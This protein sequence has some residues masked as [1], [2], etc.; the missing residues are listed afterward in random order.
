[1]RTDARIFTQNQREGCP[2]TDLFKKK[3]PMNHNMVTHTSSFPMCCFGI[4]A[5]LLTT[6]VKVLKA[7]K[8]P[9]PQDWP[10]CRR[11][12]P[13]LLLFSLASLSDST[14][15]LLESRPSSVSSPTLRCTD[16]GPVGSMASPLGS[17]STL[18]GD[19]AG[20]ADSALGSAAVFSA[21]P[22]NKNQPDVFQLWI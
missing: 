22:V 5:P 14:E 21:S 3:S 6:K 12:P 18:S 16:A 2:R 1:M 7:N 17:T 13:L 9:G 20:A 11:G 4:R 10:L 19:F 15:V 8:L